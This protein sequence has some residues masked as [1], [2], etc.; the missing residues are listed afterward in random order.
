MRPFVPLLLVLVA[1][2][3]SPWPLQPPESPV[4]RLDL[5]GDGVM[6]ERLVTSDGGSGYRQFWQCARDGASGDA[7]C[8]VQSYTA[9]SLFAAERRVADP[10]ANNRAESLLPDIPCPAYDPESASQAALSQLLV[11]TPTSGSYTPTLRWFPGLPADQASVC[12]TVAQAEKFP[13]GLAFEA[14]GEFTPEQLAAA[15]W[16]LRYLAA[17]PQLTPVGQQH[18]RTPKLVLEL[19]KLQIYQHAHAL[20]VYDPALHRHAWLANFAAPT[21]D[22]F[23]LD[24]WERIDSVSAAGPHTLEVQ[25]QQA[26]GPL[27]IEL[28][29]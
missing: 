23:K 8:A 4:E 9:Y 19:G 10:A 14:S 25:L 7:V 20:A 6:D 11:P 15:G 17:W 18:N 22:G 1:A 2:T 16:T 26:E 29:P 27:R 3:P 28:P 12:M 5:N 24:R 13:G 21:G